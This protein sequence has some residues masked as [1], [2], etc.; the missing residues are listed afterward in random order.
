MRV[1]VRRAAVQVEA[2]GG[3]QGADGLGLRRAVQRL[4]DELAGVDAVDG[5]GDRA[6][7]AGQAEAGGR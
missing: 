3:G 6:E 1:A 7:G 4:A 2:L 5:L